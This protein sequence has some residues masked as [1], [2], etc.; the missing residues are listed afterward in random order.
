MP[1]GVEVA[2]LANLKEAAIRNQAEIS[3]VI[4]ELRGL[5]HHFQSTAVN[6]P[7][8][9]SDKVKGELTD[10]VSLAVNDAADRII[11]KHTAANVQAEG[12]ERAYA[13][14]VRWSFT[15]IF[16][17]GLF[18]FVAGIGGMV[19]TAWRILPDYETLT[20]LQREKARLE[21]VV[22]ELEQRG[23]TAGLSFCPDNGRQRRCVRTNEMSNAEPWRRDGETYRIIY[24]Y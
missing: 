4:Q 19:L 9:V 10:A 24:G 7:R 15:R 18:F 23:G 12:A 16:A 14:A 2:A 8:S 11:K 17:I 6:L 3:Q 22:A 20:R 21:Q 13:R 1:N 5:T